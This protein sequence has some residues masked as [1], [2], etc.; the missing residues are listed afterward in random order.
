M[1]TPTKEQIRGALDRLHANAD[2]NGCLQDFRTVQS[3][4][5]AGGD[6]RISAAKRRLG[7]EKAIHTRWS[8]LPGY[9]AEKYAQSKMNEIEQIIYS[10]ICYLDGIPGQYLT[11]P[12]TTAPK[13]E[14]GE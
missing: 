8:E 13:H 4:L 7:D 12:S 9:E 5:D 3:A 1:T 14:G 10:T 2:Y 11:Q 6:E